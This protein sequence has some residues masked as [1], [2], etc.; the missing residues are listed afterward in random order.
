M[1]PPPGVAWGGPPRGGF[2]GGPR[3]GG[4]SNRGGGFKQERKANQDP[5]PNKA[6]AAASTSSSSTPATKKEEVEVTLSPVKATATSPPIVKSDV[7]E[8]SVGA[9]GAMIKCAPCGID[10]IGS[11]VREYYFSSKCQEP[12]NRVLGIIICPNFALLIRI[13][14]DMLL[15]YI[16]VGICAVTSLL[17]IP[18]YVFNIVETVT[19]RLH[20]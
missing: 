15:I 12:H 17:K 3:G 1:G 2:R 10:I 18:T 16:N 13:S 5:S 14:N 11:E 7:K 6:A 20:Y 8:E 4:P 9:G 19:K